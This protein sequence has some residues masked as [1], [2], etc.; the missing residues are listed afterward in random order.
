MG[1]NPCCDQYHRRRFPPTFPCAAGGHGFKEID[2]AIAEALVA[3]SPNPETVRL[4][5]Q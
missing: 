2:A 4:I 5:G 1:Y 3:G